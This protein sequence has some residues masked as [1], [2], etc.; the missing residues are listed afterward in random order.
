MKSRSNPDIKA[1]QVHFLSRNARPVV[2]DGGA[3]R[4]LP[5]LDYGISN[6]WWTSEKRCTLIKLKAAEAVIGAIFH[7]C[8]N[9]AH[10][11]QSLSVNSF[12]SAI[13]CRWLATT[14]NKDKNPAANIWLSDL[15]LTSVLFPPPASDQITDDAC[16]LTRGSFNTSCSAPAEDPQ[17]TC[18][19]PREP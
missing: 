9:L 19:A 4:N 14:S 12:V 5:H 15:S 2:E 7:P 18:F 3:S 13:C 6:L 10:Y 11:S 1:G 16:D 17:K 8:H